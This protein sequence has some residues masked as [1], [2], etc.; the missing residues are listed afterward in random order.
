MLRTNMEWDQGVDGWHDALAKR[1]NGFNSHWLPL[2]KDNMSYFTKNQIA[3]ILN[4]IGIKPNIS[5]G[6]CGGTTF[7]YGKLG[8]NGYWEY[9]LKV[10]Y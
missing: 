2:D 5:S 10:E 8:P 4:L 1:R 6:I 7:G 3:K 9:E